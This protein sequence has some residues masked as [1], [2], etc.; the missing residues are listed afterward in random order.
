MY[1]GNEPS[2]CYWL[3]KIMCDELGKVETEERKVQTARV[4][5]VK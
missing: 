3:K 1:A 5:K 4:R 2:G